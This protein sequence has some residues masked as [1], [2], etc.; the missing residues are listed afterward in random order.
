MS[1]KSKSALPKLLLAQLLGDDPQLMF[2]VIVSSGLA[3]VASQLHE[4]GVEATSEYWPEAIKEAAEIMAEE[5]KRAFSAAA[6]KNVSQFVTEVALHLEG[7]ATDG[8]R[9]AS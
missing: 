1:S 2:R 8:R 3:K 9:M 5:I 6:V 7:V 4:Q